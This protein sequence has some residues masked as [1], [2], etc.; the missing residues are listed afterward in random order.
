MNLKACSPYLRSGLWLLFVAT[1]MIGSATPPSFSARPSNH[2][3]QP[4]RISSEQAIALGVN[5]LE[6][7]AEGY[8]LRHP[9]HT[10]EFLSDGVHFTPRQGG[11]EWA[12]QLT[13][14]GANDQ[15]L[16]AVNVGA[17]KPA[18]DQPG[19]IAYSRGAVIE[20]YIAQTNVLEQQF[21]IPHPLP[22]GSADLVIAGRVTSA[23]AFEASEANAKD[24][25]VWRA[26]EGAVRLGNVYVYDATGRALSA[27]MSVT[28]STTRIVVEGAALARAA[29]P[30]TVDPEIGTN[31]FRLSDIGTDG[32][33]SRDAFDPAV[34]YNSANNEYLVVWQGDDDTGSLADQEYEIYGQ[35]LNAATG[36]EVGVNDFRISD[37]GPDGDSAYNAVNSAI[38][39]NSAHNEYRVVWI[40][41][42]DIL[43][44]V[45]DEDEIFGQRINAATG[46]EVGTN[47]FRL[48][49]M[50]PN[51]SASFEVHRPAIAYNSVSNEYLVVWVGDDDTGLLVS[52]EDEI[53]YQRVYGD[54]A[55]GDE[56][57]ANDV[58]VSDMGPDGNVNYDAYES[59][60]AYNSA[61]NEYLVVWGGDDNVGTLVDGEYEVFGQRLSAAGGLLGT[62]DFRISDMGPDGNTSYGGSSLGNLYPAVAYNSANNEY[63]VVWNSD[64]DTGSLVNDEVEIFGQRLTATTGVEVG[65]NDFQLSDMG[66][67]GSAAYRAYAPAVAYDSTAN[68]YAVVWYGD[69]NI[70]PLGSLQFEIFGQRLNAAT[71]VEVG[72][73]DFRLSDMGPDGAIAYA[74]VW[75]AAAFNNLNNEYLVVWSGDDDT[76]PLVGD[77]AEIF[78]QRYISNNRLFLPLTMRNYPPCFAGPSEV[79]PNDDFLQA[80][81][82]LCVGVTD[83]TGYHNGATEDKDYFQFTVATAGTITLQLVAYANTDPQIALYN[84]SQASVGFSG[85]PPYSIIYSGAAGTYYARVY[86]TAN[87]GANSYTLRVTYP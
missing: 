53:Y 81:G 11:P 6:A 4:A 5:D 44:L 74:G 54:R 79:E 50:G 42:D 23:G 41:D 60:V 9:R 67:D 80:N 31:D 16:Y 85:G 73:N 76:L 49:D 39:Y 66:P 20:Q 64:D 51:G 69:D 45:N 12:W 1:L 40:G 38:A 77:E 14:V 71:S 32:D 25:W 58:R 57:G 22:L 46:A 55:L 36:A 13:F 43:P 29:Y 37:M 63:L 87:Y 26:G 59:A 27:E 68:E 2:L 65:V 21:I 18:H 82:P 78:G 83:F 35:R 48:S 30:V 56:T 52:G 75:P 84:Q 19:L 17:V 15:S 34:A 61:N 86:T 24:G 72:P 47:D 3:R 33:A 10:A 62:N 8:R 70:P 28:A 7:M